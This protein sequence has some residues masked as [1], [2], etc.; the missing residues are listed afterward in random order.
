MNLPIICLI[1]LLLAGG[2]LL[3]WRQHNGLDVWTGKPLPIEL[4]R[5]RN[6]G[7]KITQ[8]GGLYTVR[9]PSRSL[10]AHL[11]FVWGLPTGAV[12]LS[13]CGSRLDAVLP[14]WIPRY[15][16]ARDPVC[17]EWTDQTGPRAGATFR[18]DASPVKVY[19]FYEAELDKGRWGSVGSANS[20]YDRQGLEKKYGQANLGASGDDGRRIDVFIFRWGTEYTAIAISFRVEKSRT[21]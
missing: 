20:L 2:G 18:T 12:T 9:D 7:L 1:V 11:S 14:E 4:V 10:M 6:P 8:A 17:A 19:K 13:A 15:P 16:D 3:F 21:R 5:R